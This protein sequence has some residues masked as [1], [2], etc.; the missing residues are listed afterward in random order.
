MVVYRCGFKIG[1]PNG[2]SVNALAS[3]RCCRPAPVAEEPFCR[4]PGLDWLFQTTSSKLYDLYYQPRLHTARLRAS[5]P[6]VEPRVTGYY[7]GLTGLDSTRPIGPRLRLQRCVM[8][9]KDIRSR[10]SVNVRRRLP[11]SLVLRLTCLSPPP[12]QSLVAQLRNWGKL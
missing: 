12:S 4:H 2:V 8:G 5:A 9:W 10:S 3:C 11:P 6:A 1:G 7:R